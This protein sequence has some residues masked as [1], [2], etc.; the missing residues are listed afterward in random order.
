M[1]LI[2]LARDKERQLKFTDSVWHSS[3]GDTI[4][5]FPSIFNLCYSLHIM[6]RLETTSWNIITE[7]SLWNTYHSTYRAMWEF[8]FFFLYTY[9]DN[10]TNSMVTFIFFLHLFYRIKFSNEK[11]INLQTNDDSNL[12]SSIL[13]FFQLKHPTKLSLEKTLFLIYSFSHCCNVVSHY[14]KKLENQ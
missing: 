3:I 2:F 1:C 4:S 5:S 7:P 10:Y 14:N 8:N 11:L 13:F 6:L 12:P 9:R